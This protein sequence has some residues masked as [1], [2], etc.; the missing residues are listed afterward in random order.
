RMCL[1]DIDKA[2]KPLPACSTPATEGMKIS[3]NSPKA[4]MAQKGVMEFLLINHPLDCPI[5]DQGGECEL[6][7]VAMGYGRDVSRYQEKKRVVK[8]K[9]L[10]PLISTDMTRCIHCTRCL[11]FGQE[12]GG[13]MELG[14]TGRGEHMEVGT[15]IEKSMVSEMSGN[16]IDL[17]PV[18]AL[19]SKPFRYTARPWEMTSRDS[20]APHDSVGSNI[21][22]HIRDNRVMRVVPR[23][24]E[25]INEVWISD[26]DRFSYQGLNSA[27]RLETPLI[28][29]DGVWHETDWKTAL[30]VTVQGLHKVIAQHGAGALGALASP[31]ATLEELYL[32][33]KL[34]RGIGCMN[35]DHRLRQT[36]FHNQEHGPL[37]PSLGQSIEDLEQLDAALLIG[38]NVRKEQP[39]AG[40]RLRKAALR[41]AH[42]MFINPL[43]Y[44]IHFKVEEKLISSPADMISALA[45]VAKALSQ[46]A[47]VKGVEGLDSLLAGI[48]A[49]ETQRR[50]AS[51]LRS[52][53]RVTVLLGNPALAHPHYSQLHALAEAVALMS[54]ANFGYLAE[55]A[56]SAGAWLAG[57]VPHRGAAGQTVTQAG[58]DAAAMLTGNLKGYVLMGVEPEFDSANP[59]AAQH[60]LHAADFV[61]TLSAFQ[62]QTMR[63]YASV[64]LP[65][66]AF[67]ETSGTFVNLEGRWQNFTGAVTPP[68]EARPAWKVLRVLGNLFNIPG[69]E[70]V[71][72]EEV[73]SELH[74]LYEQ[75]QGSQQ[76]RAQGVALAGIILPSGKASGLQR[77]GDVPP[78]AADGLVRRATALQATIDAGSAAIHINESLATRLSLTN[79]QLAVAKQ[80][81][82]KVKLPVII[83]KRVPDDC[84]LIPAGLPQTTQLGAAFGPLEL[85]KA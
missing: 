61:V 11:R 67:V 83:D 47:G 19:T 52:G 58:L 23:D 40:H 18:G 6:Q 4:I 45:G 72:S 36:D 78:Y 32:L 68:G 77:I 29:K 10:G 1:V 74:N 33:Q 75:A 34:M 54:G 44:D 15:Y 84:V 64:M 14:A 27:D 43:D 31:T 80:G 35:I 73:R 79:G 69:F 50:M 71:S 39:I 65:I 9:N 48:E 25:Q 16:V 70:Y 59:A 17:C 24:N 63:E 62:S 55:A 7:D 37:Y 8:D 28:K 5:C 42:I 12:I 13:L 49:S 51:Y 53:R 66:A 22:L 85:E 41:G 38:S 20:I 56:N 26:R 82:S 30:D 57:A 46:L 21:A 76:S 2:A 81:Q 60:A 3:T